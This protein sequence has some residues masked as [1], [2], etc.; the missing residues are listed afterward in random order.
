VL[1]R[2]DHPDT[3]F[4]LDPPYYQ[5]RSDRDHY[6]VGD[7]FSHDE[8]VDELRDLE[9]DW[10]ISYETLPPGLE[11]VAA[12]AETYTA[13]YSMS[14]DDQRQERTEHVVMSFDPAESRLFAPAQQTTLDQLSREEGGDRGE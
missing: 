2:Y 1:A 4:Y 3:V 7:N 10:L 11:E 9:A 6:R 5:T 8:L 12:T 13:M 14:Y